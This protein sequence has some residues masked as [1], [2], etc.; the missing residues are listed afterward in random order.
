MIPKITPGSW[1]YRG[2]N[3]AVYSKSAT[4][5]YGSLIFRFHEEDSPN[6]ADLSLILIAP[7][8]LEAL[9][10]LLDDVGRDSSLLGAVKARAALSRVMKGQL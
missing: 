4:H 6:D 3:D 5:P 9:N 2:K 7:E 10:D 8:L 1:L